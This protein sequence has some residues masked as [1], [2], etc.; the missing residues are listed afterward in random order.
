MSSESSGSLSVSNEAREAFLTLLPAI[1]RIAC[2]EFRHAPS[3]RRSEL[4]DDA[5]VLAFA[6]YV[7]LVRAGKQGLAYATALAKYAAKRVRAGR[8][9]GT[10]QS[11][12]DVM[13]RQAQQRLGFDVA[14]LSRSSNRASWE[15]LTDTRSVSPA[16]V[17]M[18]RLHFRDWL[19]Q[20]RPLERRVAS[21][22]AL[23]YRT[24]ELAN[25]VGV[26]P[27]RISQLRRLLE[28]NWLAFEFSCRG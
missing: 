20:L 4:V 13:S 24:G 12:K 16:E 8:R 10:R 3:S 28:Q 15:E 5:V 25:S 14:F 18:C 21:Q 23:G 1:K 26:T 19:R 6:M 2:F 7:R 11:T 17:A 22:L 9:F 27:A